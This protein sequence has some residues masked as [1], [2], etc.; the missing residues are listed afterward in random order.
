MFNVRSASS[1]PLVAEANR[2]A[3]EGVENFQWSLVGDY[4]DVVENG[5]LPFLDLQ[6]HVLLASCSSTLLKASGLLPLPGSRS[7]VLNFRRPGSWKKEITFPKTITDQSLT[8]FCQYANGLQSLCLYSSFVLTD[9]R[10]I[11]KLTSLKT[12]IINSS[13]DDTVQDVSYLRHLPKLHTLSLLTVLKEDLSFLI[14]NRQLSNL[15][16][17]GCL[18]VADCSFL[19][20][21]PKLKRLDLSGTDV[22][23][24]GVKNGFPA[25]ECLNLSFTKVKD[26]SVF[27]KG[28]PVLRVLNL[29][30][31]TEIVDVESLTKVLSLEHL[32]VKKTQITDVPVLGKNLKSLNM[33]RCYRLEDISALGEISTLEHLELSQTN[34]SDLSALRKLRKLKTL[35]L[36]GCQNLE[37]VSALGEVVSLENLNLEQ[38]E[39][40]KDVSSLVNLHKLR[41]LNIRNTSIINVVV[42]TR[43]LKHLTVF[44]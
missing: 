29:A 35:R 11:K 12:V 13:W 16:L 23:D 10:A 41:S 25:L 8:K 26:I 20:H 22:T 37:D 40:L 18:G 39:K 19:V 30:F 33:S 31:C 1:K 9:L 14:N 2:P 24:L 38:C 42:L 17:S 4:R 21:L 44:Y 5:I 27:N 3:A 36:H 15:D 34:L 28:F 43:H 32:N 7:E 6:S